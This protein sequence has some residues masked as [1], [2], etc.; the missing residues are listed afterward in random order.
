VIDFNAMYRE[1]AAPMKGGRLVC[2]TC[3]KVHPLRAEEYL[4]H[5]WPKCCGYTVRLITAREQ[6]EARGK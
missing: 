6:K 3:R 2:Q 5:G 4:R 1:M